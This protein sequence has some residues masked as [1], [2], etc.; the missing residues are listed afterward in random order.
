MWKVATWN[1]N[2]VKARLDR[3]IAFLQR[4]RPDVIL[5]QELKCET[6]L[7]PLEAIQKAGYYAAVSGQKAYNGVAIVSLR[8]ATD[9][10]I[11]LGD[12]EL[13]EARLI[14]ATVDGIRLASAYVPNGQAVGSEKYQY[15]LRWLARLRSYL[16]A[17]APRGSRFLLG[18]DFNV[19]PEDRD[20]YDPEGWRG[21]ILFSEPEKAALAEIVA[22][23]LHDTF[24]KFRT[25]AGL[26]SWWDY[27]MM[28]FPKNRGLRIDFLLASSAL[29]AQCTASRIDRNERKGL[30]PSDH[31]PVIAEFD[32]K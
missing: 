22:A 18:G 23:D 3:L 6:P 32:L 12:G 20:C 24:R 26:Y 5:L 21:Q 31:A 25:E 2:S 15:K 7:F 14:A 1:V 19:A 10:V 30:L 28:G 9:V 11:G 4:E 13:D 17:Q 16:N 29:Y 27:R 8:P